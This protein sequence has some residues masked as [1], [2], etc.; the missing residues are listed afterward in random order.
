MQQQLHTP[1]QG[2]CFPKFIT[3][4]SSS[5][6]LPP[7]AQGLSTTDLIDGT[8]PRHA[9]LEGDPIRSRCIASPEGIHNALERGGGKY[10]QLGRR[11]L[12]T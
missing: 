3:A 2:P 6:S 12:V 1:C 7:D 11:N 5:S 10:G 4:T 9:S 8:E